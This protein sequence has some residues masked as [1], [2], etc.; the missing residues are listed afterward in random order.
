M[1][2]MHP[3]ATIKVDAPTLQQRYDKLRELITV[4]MAECRRLEGELEGLQMEA[5]N[6][7][8]QILSD[9]EAQP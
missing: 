9:R 4:K 6:V 3:G 2:Y 5:N 7:W 1:N 8:R